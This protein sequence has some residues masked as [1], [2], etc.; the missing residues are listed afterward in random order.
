MSLS[1]RSLQCQSPSYVLFV[2][3]FV[4][5]TALLATGAAINTTESSGN[6]YEVFK[7]ETD[8]ETFRRT[9]NLTRVA[10]KPTNAALHPGWPETLVS[11]LVCVYIQRVVKWYND[12][13]A[14]GEYEV[15]LFSLLLSDVQV[16]EWIISFG[17]LERNKDTAGWANVI[18]WVSTLVVASVDCPGAVL[19]P[20]AGFSW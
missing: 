8:I 17:L 11:I 14:L 18:W 20:V 7:S 15:S 12:G 5:T 1:N 4:L 2:L 16:I 3:G 6:R 10:A 13:M 9:Y 19:Y